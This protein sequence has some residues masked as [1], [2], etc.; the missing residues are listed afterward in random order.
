MY[1]Y[2]SKLNSFECTIL[3][4][5]IYIYIYILKKNIYIEIYIYNLDYQ[6]NLV[7]YIT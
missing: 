4:I 6:A 3:Y 5:Y 7:Y 2:Y 1:I